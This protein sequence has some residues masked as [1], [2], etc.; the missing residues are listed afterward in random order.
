M[1]LDTGEKMFKYFLAE[2]RK[3]R[4]IVIT[5]L[6]WT[7]FVNPVMIDWVKTKF[8]DREFNQKRID[9]LEAIK[10]ITDS[11]QWGYIH[12]LYN[13]G[14]SFPIPYN[15]EKLPRYMFGLSA[16]FGWSKIDEKG[17]GDSDDGE[18]PLSPLSSSTPDNPVPRQNAFKFDKRVGG[19]IFRSDKR[20]LHSDNPYRKPDDKTF[21]YFEQG[22]GSIKGISAKKN[23]NRR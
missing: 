17:T 15:D 5:P 14:N 22:G 21:I 18:D 9:D 2:V 4:T 1:V 16:E 12:S 23:T 19:K 8:P 13:T 7:E 6:Q 11:I 10:V 3:E 20:V